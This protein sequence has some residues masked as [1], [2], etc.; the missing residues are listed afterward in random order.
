VNPLRV[1]LVFRDARAGTGGLGVHVRDLANGLGRRGHHVE[2]VTVAPRED[3]EPY[4]FIDG[5]EI[6]ALAPLVQRQFA[7]DHAL[8]SGT[9]RA[10]HNGRE[11]VVHVFSCVPA[12]LHMAAMVS[13]RHSHQPLVWTP[14]LHPARRE[15]WAE[16]GLRG[17]AMRFFDAVFPRIAR[18]TDAVVAATEEEAAAFRRLGSRRVEVIPP[19]APQAGLIEAGEAE[20]L[21]ARYGIGA[22]PLAVTVVRRLERRKGLSFCLEAFGRLRQSVPAARLLIVGLRNLGGLD[23]PDGVVVAGPLSDS[24]LASAYRAADVIFVPSSYEAFSLVVIEAWQ[25]GRPVVVTDRVGLAESVRSGGGSVVPFG[26]SAAAARALTRFMTDK[27]AS[28]KEGRRGRATVQ[29]GFLVDDLV[30][31]LVSLYREL[32]NDRVAA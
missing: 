15:V 10:I 1:A 9:G 29:Q 25:Q 32:P 14:M 11:T 8:V 28:D 17:R 5:V 26:D 16:Y 24:D 2:V 22:E 3:R 23:V 18:F 6:R 20:S 7:L 12:Y 21:R 30:D 4:G 13:A 31:R 19:A 27:A